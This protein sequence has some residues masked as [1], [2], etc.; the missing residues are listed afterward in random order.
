MQLTAEESRTREDL[1]EWIATVGVA[2]RKFMESTGGVQALSTAEG[3]FENTV[4]AMR[5]KFPEVDY[6]PVKREQAAMMCGVRA[7]YLMALFAM[8]G[9]V[10]KQLG[11]EPTAE[12]W[13]E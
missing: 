11:L 8:K 1:R 3:F 10:D 6:D 7:G 13:G 5:P 12:E 9:M 4:T 2:T